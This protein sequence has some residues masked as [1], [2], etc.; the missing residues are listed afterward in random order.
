MSLCLRHWRFFLLLSFL[1]PSLSQAAYRYEFPTAYGELKSYS[2]FYLRSLQ[3]YRG[4]IE[5]FLS[6]E[7]PSE[8]AGRVFPVSFRGKSEMVNGFYRLEGNFGTALCDDQICQIRYR[9]LPVDEM[10]VVSYLNGISQ[11]P[12]EFLARVR[13]NI[14]FTSNPFALLWMRPS[15]ASMGA[16]SF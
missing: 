2:V 8:I 15:Q 14:E 11:S 3:W 13:L 6:F 10:Q 12:E 7:I 1:I 4:S 5:T 9:D 16:Y